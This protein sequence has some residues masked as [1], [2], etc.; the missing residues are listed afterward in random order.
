MSVNHPKVCTCVQALKT[1]IVAR[2]PVAPLVSVCSISLPIRVET[3]LDYEALCW[4]GSIYI[5][6]VDL[7]VAADC[8]SGASRRKAFQDISRTM[9]AGRFGTPVTPTPGARADS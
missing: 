4:T 8:N 1:L 9:E 3:E 2:D 7:K 6:Y 5:L